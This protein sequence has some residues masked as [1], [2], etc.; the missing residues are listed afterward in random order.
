MLGYAQLSSAESRTTLVVLTDVV[1]KEEELA[2]EKEV[3]EQLPACFDDA[4]LMS[5]I[6]AGADGAATNL[7]M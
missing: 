4:V 7:P 1:V 3:G 5:E 2:V 6:E